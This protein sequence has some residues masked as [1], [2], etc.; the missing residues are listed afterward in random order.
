[1]LRYVA[2]PLRQKWPK[3]ATDEID[4]PFSAGS[5]E[6][7]GVGRALERAGQPFC[8]SK[9]RWPGGLLGC[10]FDNAASRRRRGPQASVYKAASQQRQIGHGARGAALFKA[11]VAGSRTALRTQFGACGI[12]GLHG[13]PRGK[14]QGWRMK[15]LPRSL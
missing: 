14:E 5:L 9:A 10:G 13:R 6:S 4:K 15:A 1:M 12:L 11:K 2:D 3:L 8:S 7:M